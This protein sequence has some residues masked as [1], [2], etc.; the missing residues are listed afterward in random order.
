MEKHSAEQIVNGIKYG[1]KLQSLEAAHQID[2]SRPGL[3]LVVYHQ[4]MGG[5]RD[6]C[7]SCRSEE[8]GWR[9]LH[10]SSDVTAS[11][12]SSQVASL[13]MEKRIKTKN[14]ELRI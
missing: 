4:F 3:D 8:A 10:S 5:L 11:A 12:F 7:L 2:L 13:H 9:D 14:S 1:S 6:R